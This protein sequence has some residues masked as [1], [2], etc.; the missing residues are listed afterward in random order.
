M[1]ADGADRENEVDL[2]GAAELMTP[3][4]MAFLV[5]QTSGIV[6]APMSGERCAELRLPQMVERNTDAHGTAFTVSVDHVD[7]GT[8]VSAAARTR[9]VRALADHDT[10]AEQLHRP[11]HVFPLRARDGGVL[12]RAGH[13]EAAVDLLA[14]AGLCQVGVISELVAAGGEMLRGDQAAGFADEHGLPLVAVA[15]VV[16]YRTHIE[17]LLKD[18]ASATMPTV[19]GAS[20]AI[21]GRDALDGT[22]HLAWPG[23]DDI[24]APSVVSRSA[25]LIADEGTGLIVYLRGYEGRASDWPT[26]STRTRYRIRD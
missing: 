6:C 23:L 22:E 18:V 17:K 20:R 26:R 3:E 21:A 9:T 5:S 14:I 16:R 1:V 19:F 13:T 11:G 15:D 10:L 25:E 24:A 7:S 8:G 2:V 4:K 12:A